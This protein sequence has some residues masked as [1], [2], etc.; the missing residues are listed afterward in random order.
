MSVD[1]VADRP[2]HFPKNPDVFRFDAEV[3]AI[4]P[5]MARR[6]IPMYAEAH[7]LHVALL[8]ERLLHGNPNI[9][10]YDIGA[11]RGHFFKEI[12][13]Q[14]CVP[15]HTGDSRLNFLA[16]DNSPDMLSA[17]KAEMPWVDTLLGDASNLPNLPAQA[18]VICMFY[19]LQFLPTEEKKIKLLRWA[20]RHLKPGGVLLMGQKDEPTETYREAFATEY[21]S[22][23]QRNG[24]SMDE[25]RA[26]TDA[27]KNSMWPSSPSWPESQC[28]TA[29]FMDYTETTRWLQFSTSMCTK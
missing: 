14:A 23:R 10:V 4:F 6:S 29:G 15:E 24:Y 1:V 7:R 17:L 12:C 3:T 13:K 26:K 20:Y 11:S 2:V 9:T 25:I 18:D 5:N 19:I 8:S 21:Y 22:F 28:Y 16:V 27:L